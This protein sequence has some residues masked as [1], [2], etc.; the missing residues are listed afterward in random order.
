MLP[1]LIIVIAADFLAASKP[2]G[3][4][5]CEN[6][7]LCAAT[8]AVSMQNAN[9]NAAAAGRATP[10]TKVDAIVIW[11][12]LKSVPDDAGKWRDVPAGAGN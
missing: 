10:R 12:L 7:L 11:P 2:F 5:I 4:G 1:E 8:G 9:H 3:A 6:P